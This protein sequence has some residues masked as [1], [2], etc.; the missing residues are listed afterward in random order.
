MAER[1]N[2]DMNQTV[3]ALQHLEELPRFLSSWTDV[4]QIPS[5]K[6]GSFPL[7]MRK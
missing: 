1:H 5:V 6:T 7:E 3:A 4:F 2:P